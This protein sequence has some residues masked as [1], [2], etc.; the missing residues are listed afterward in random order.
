VLGEVL[1][2]KS[3]RIAVIG[4]IPTTATSGIVMDLLSSLRRDWSSRKLGNS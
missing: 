3:N 4:T 2:A 1:A